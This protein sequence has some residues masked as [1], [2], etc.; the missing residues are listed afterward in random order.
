MFLVFFGNIGRL[1][2]FSWLH[3]TWKWTIRSARF[4]ENAILSIV[5]ELFE[6]NV[7]IK[8]EYDNDYGGNV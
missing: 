1:C 8:G 3:H 5:Y 2:G 4:E 6:L 7:V